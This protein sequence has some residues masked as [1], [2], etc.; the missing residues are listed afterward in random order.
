MSKQM[1]VDVAIIGA[2]TGGMYALREVRRTKQS[3][4]LID[5]GPLGTTCARV[6]C[7]PSK[8]ALHIAEYWNSQKEFERYGISGSEHLRLDSA[9]A[10]QALRDQRDQFSDGAA[11]NAKKA[12][13]EHLI[14]G[15]ARFL[16]PTLLEVESESSTQQINAKSV[17]IAAGSRPV[18]PEFLQPF[19]EYCITTDEFFEMQELP[20]SIG[21]LGLGAIG[22]EMGLALARLGVEVH[23]ADMAQTVGGITDPEVSNV[24]LAEFGKE[25]QLYLGAPAELAKAEKGVLLKAGDKEVLVDKVLVA[26]GRRPNTDQ[27]NLAEAGFE[28]D[29]RGQP[30]FNPNTLQ[31][32]KHPVFIV[33][34]IN[35]YRPLMHEAADEG[36]MAGYNATQS[37]PVAF[38]RKTSLAIAF[39]NPDVI[40]VGARFDE[41]NQDDVLIGTATSQANGRSRVITDRQGVLRLY[42]DKSSGTLLGASMVGVRAEHVAQLLALAIE[43]N[44][45]AHS[46]LQLAFYHPVVE[47]IIQ[48][49]LQDIARHIPDP[50]GLPFG[51]VL[52]DV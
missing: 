32:G 2:G 5:S 47:E 6:G 20:K 45:T 39:T 25:M 26:L 40:S 33:G 38:K 34:D 30:L 3:F 50:A 23:G 43:R 46:L 27:L 35:G 7:M 31:V 14:M 29:E 18:M 41:L 4:V 1:N 22:L 17:I 11:G 12:A 49:A 52:A 9:V 44:E 36:A 10:W 42:A 48:S 19:A 24:A 51:L 16:E 13:G 21:I 37:T 8:V 28:L 15:R